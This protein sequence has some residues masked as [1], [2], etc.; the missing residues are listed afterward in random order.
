M[1]KLIDGALKFMEENFAE[2]AE[3]FGSLANT[4]KPHTLFIV[5]KQRRA[6]AA[7]AVTADDDI[8]YL[9]RIQRVFDRRRSR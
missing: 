7:V 3:L 8:F 2:H 4:Q 1:D 6:A 9:Q 5:V